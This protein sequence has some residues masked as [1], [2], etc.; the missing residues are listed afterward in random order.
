MISFYESNKNFLKARKVGAS[1]TCSA[2]QT[3]TSNSMNDFFYLDVQILKYYCIST[4]HFLSHFPLFL[5]IFMNCVNITFVI[6]VNLFYVPF[7]FFLLDCCLT[8]SSL[9]FSNSVVN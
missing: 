2:Y 6:L 3:R 5:K 1:L 7:L 8:I 9:T 4:G